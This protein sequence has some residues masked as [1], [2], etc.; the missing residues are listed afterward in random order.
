MRWI[1]IDGFE[2]FESGRRAVAVKNISLAEEHLHHKYP[3]LPLMPPPLMIEG[4][5]QTAGILVGEARSFAEKVI[6]AKI[7]KA[8]FEGR[9]VPGD[10]LRYE[11]EIETINEAGAATKGKVFCNDRPIGR[12]DLFFSHV[13]QN[14]SG[15]QFPKENF[16]FTDQ[17]RALLASIQGDLERPKDRPQEEESHS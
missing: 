2:Q 15:L 5:A 17:F 6:L 8:R 3:G 14:L 7:R 10:R 13:D 4:M 1:W 9:V 16:V 12:I 11:A